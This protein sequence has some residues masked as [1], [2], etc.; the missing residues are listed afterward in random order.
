[1]KKAE[2]V[3]T[4]I[5]GFDPMI[6]GGFK[7]HSVNMVAGG[8]GCGKTI[9][10]IQFLYNGILK[11][12]PGIYITFEEKKNK[13]Y[14]DFMTFGWDFAKYEKQGKFVFLEYTPEQVKKVLVEGGGIIDSIIHKIGAKR[15]VIDSIS[16]FALLYADEL[17]Q[18]ESSLAL[19]DLISRW[20]CTAICT[21][22][23][24]WGTDGLD[25]VPLG[26][27]VDGI[28]LLYHI[29]HRGRRKRA[30]EVLKMRGTKHPGKTFSFQIGKNGITIKPQEI[31][32]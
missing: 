23:T 22:Q 26:Y 4:G 17:A 30:V 10:A 32:F 12:E 9:F 31:V 5:K 16:S 25:D 14:D 1:M 24:S 15:L 18:K 7:K 20:G 8:A 6:E 19:F 29:K 11:G 2:R 3:A 13:L 27:E 21:S 28:V